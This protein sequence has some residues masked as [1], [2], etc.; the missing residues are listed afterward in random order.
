MSTPV[1]VAVYDSLADWEIGHITAHV[2]NGDFQR[3]PGR[4]R[5]VTVGRSREPITTKGGMRIT[6]DTTLDA[7]AT[8]DS[9]ML[10]L[11]G[12]DTWVP[13]GDTSFADKAREFLAAGVP[14][15][16]ICGATFGLAAAGL[17]DEV[18]HTSNAAEFLAMSGYSGSQHYRDE[19]A[20][21]GGDVIT[22]SGIAPVEFA[23]QVFARLDL[24]ES[25]TLESWYKL[26]G[27]NDPSGYYELMETV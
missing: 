25:G 23:R 8:H 3:E 18:A 9:A 16:A 19:L 6:P 27:L 14:V 11:A 7:I 2:N 15:A 5:V 26:Y 22:A 10:I 1:H 12:A 20:V 17:L 13:G 21:T 4:Y 24:Y